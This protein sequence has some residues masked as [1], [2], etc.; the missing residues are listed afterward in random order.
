VRQGDINLR[1]ASRLVATLQ[2][3]GVRHA[4]ISPGSRSTPLVL[5]AARQAG[6][7]THVLA[8]ERSAAFFALGVG[9]H[10][11]V[12]ALVIGTSGSAPANW[13]PAL[14]EASRGRV[15]LLALSADRPPELHECGANQTLDQ[16]H[17]FGRFVRGFHA[18]DADSAEPARLDALASRAAQAFDQSLWPLAGPVHLNIAFREPLLGDGDAQAGDAAP[19]FRIDRPRCEPAAQTLTELAALMDGRPGLLVA[20]PARPDE[21]FAGALGELAGRLDCPLLADP[22]SGLRCGGHD[23]SRVIGGY[24]SFLRDA[25]FAAAWAPD[26]VLQFG[27]APVS[28]VLQHYLDRHAAD[29]TQVRV[30][31]AGP[32]PDPNRRGRW[33]LHADPLALVEALNR[34]PP[35]PAP[36]GW[37]AAFLERERGVTEALQALPQRPLEADV[38]E[39]VARLLPAQ[40]LV[41]A[42]NSMVIRDCDSFLRGRDAPLRLHANRGASGIDGNVST[43]FGLAAA[44]GRPVLGLLGD[45][46]LFHDMNGLAAAREADATLVVFNNGGGAIFGYLPQAE[47]AEF[48][49]FWLTDPALDLA[50]VARLHGLRY[51]LAEDAAGFGRHLARALERSGSSLIEVCVDREDSLARHREFWSRLG[52]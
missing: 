22:L 45:L 49:R 18:L 40:G 41:F 13:Y 14:V 15:P 20:G 2:Q 5:A 44:A 38:F 35:A 7:R 26:W 9:R 29:A 31:P 10:S 37:S 27:D 25:G 32:W 17:L 42:G 52:G 47:L 30:A 48:K 19:P 51:A 24:D 6:L 39:T 23:R 12:P 46:A 36:A 3:C 50:L 16:T 4:V 1:W 21:D 8:D 33:L 34:Q 28:K 43:V 11:G